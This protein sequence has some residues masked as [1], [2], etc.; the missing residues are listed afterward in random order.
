MQRAPFHIFSFPV[1]S[2]FQLSILVEMLIPQKIPILGIK[3]SRDAPK[4]KNP[5]SWRFR[6]NP[7]DFAKIRGIEI[8]KLRK[9]PNPGDKNPETEKKIPNPGDFRK[10]PG[11]FR[12]SRINSDGPKTV[13]P[14]IF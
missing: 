12:K 5:K 4:V 9:I 2:I 3:N 13:K 7:G 11:I 14:K 1:I 8:S 6:L 10:I